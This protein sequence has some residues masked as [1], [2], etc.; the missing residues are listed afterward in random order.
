[1]MREI[2]EIILL[3]VLCAARPIMILTTPAPV[4]RAIE[5]F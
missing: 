3:R 2:P 4:K 5:M 1:M